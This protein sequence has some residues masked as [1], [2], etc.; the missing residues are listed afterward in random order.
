MLNKHAAASRGASAVI[1]GG[2]FGQQRRSQRT[3]VEG[4]VAVA[5][6]GRRA[7]P[8]AGERSRQFG[9]ERLRWLPQ[10]LRRREAD[11]REVAL[12][13]AMVERQR[14]PV[15][16]LQRGG[17]RF[18]GF[19]ERLCVGHAAP[20]QAAVKRLTDVPR[21]FGLRLGWRLLAH[22]PQLRLEFLGLFQ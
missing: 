12:P 18:F 20:T 1:A 8:A 15:Q 2:D 4:D 17:D 7:Q 21:H 14:W 11:D 6:F 3:P 19:C 16:F 22:Q 9:R 5:A 10:L 13:R